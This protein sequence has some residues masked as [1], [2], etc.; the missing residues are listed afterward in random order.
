MNTYVPLATCNYQSFFHT[1]TLIQ[2]PNVMVHS[3]TVGVD[4]VYH[5]LKLCLSWILAKG[6]HNCA[7]LLRRNGAVAILVEQREGLLE[8]RDLLFCQLISLVKK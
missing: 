4:F 2:E 7:Q 6:P 5:V 8:L 1:N 3:L